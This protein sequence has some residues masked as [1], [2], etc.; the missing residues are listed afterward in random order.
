[1]GT[2]ASRLA[3]M[4]VAVTVALATFSIQSVGAADDWYARLRVTKVSPALYYGRQP[5]LSDLAK[6]KEFG[7]QTIVNT[8]LNRTKPGLHAAEAR[9]L[10]M[11]HFHLPVGFF[12]PPDKELEAFL[13]IATDPA[14]QPVY[15]HC[16]GGWHR[17]P[18]FVCTYRVRAE[19]WTYDKAYAELRSHGHFKPWFFRSLHRG[20][21]IAARPARAV[22]S[23]AGQESTKAE[24]QDFSHKAD[25]K[26]F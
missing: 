26:P 13:R 7:I 6:L 23:K 1:M 2:I 20:L 4:I 10:G 17:A 21:E 5:R 12:I 3:T 18:M 9:R 16:Q 25:R 24:T 19:G 15:I 11:K 22:A 14:N 8:R